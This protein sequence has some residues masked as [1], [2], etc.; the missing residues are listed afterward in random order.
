MA[1]RTARLLW[2]SG[3]TMLTKT[4]Y[5]Q[6]AVLLANISREMTEWHPDA[7]AYIEEFITEAHENTRK[8]LEIVKNAKAA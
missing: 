4:D 7:I 8:M 2:T 3:E 1:Q 5:E 6:K